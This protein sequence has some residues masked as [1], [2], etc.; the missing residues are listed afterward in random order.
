[1]AQNLK[2]IRENSDKSDYVKKIYKNPLLH[3]N[4]HKTKSKV[5]KLENA[6][7]SYTKRTDTCYI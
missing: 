2:V 1:M 4:S 3:K 6:Y 5:K 7:T